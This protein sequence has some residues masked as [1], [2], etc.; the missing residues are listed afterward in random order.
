MFDAITQSVKFDEP[1]AASMV[2]DLVTA[3]FYMH[4]RGLVHRDIKPENLL[5]RMHP[6]GALVHPDGPDI[7]KFSV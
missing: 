1:T 5:V 3:L 6:E 2:N 4:S 7:H